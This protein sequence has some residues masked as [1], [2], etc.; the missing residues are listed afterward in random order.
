MSFKRFSFLLA[1]R[2][3]GIMTTLMGLVFLFTTPGYHAATLLML[4]LTAALTYNVLHFISRTN[5]EIS[6][7][8]DAARYA[9]FGQRFNFKHL[10]AGFEELGDT[11]TDILERFRE[12]RTGQE[13]ELR[14][15]KALVEHVPVPLISLHQDGSITQWNNSARRL[16]GSAHVTKASDLMQFGNR[17]HEEII[18]I[19]TGE[20]KLAVFI[21]DDV[22]QR[23]TVAATQIILAGDVERLISL[24]DIQSE[25]DIA[26]LEAW[27]DLVRVLTHEIMNSITP[28]ASLAKTA[29]DLVDDVRSRV[30]DQPDL[31]E[32]LSDVKDAVKTVARRSDGLM[33]F[34]TSYRRL[35]RLPPPEKSRIAISELFN[36]V[37]LLGTHDW[38][39]NKITLNIDISP[40][41]LDLNADPKMV[42][43][44]LINMLQN[45]GHALE[46]IKNPTVWMS[47]R[48]SSRGRTI[49]EIEDNGPGIDDEIAQ[50][51]FVPFFTTKR[52]GSGVGLAL[53]RQVMIAHSGAITYKKREDGGSI[54]TLTF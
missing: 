12:V 37:Q 16:F 44:I 52:E 5:A 11:F 3:V 38:G 8:L 48:L 19:K 7:F 46:G 54:F 24:Q 20:R 27:Q 35:T 13:E 4:C 39:E 50:K 28:V 41:E 47:A 2:L 25:L 10:G 45:A 32:E 26:Q 31:V 29:E 33:Q 34:V 23:L 42:E 9:D 6:R 40:S 1:V 15:L 14:H 18:S 43:Q 36:S 30:A 17:F 22:E 51:I 21:V 49:I 53:T